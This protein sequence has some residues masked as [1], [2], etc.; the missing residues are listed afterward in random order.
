[1]IAHVVSLFFVSLSLPA[2]ALVSP[3]AA[4]DHEVGGFKCHRNIAQTQS[5]RTLMGSVLCLCC[6]FP[7]AV[8][9]SVVGRVPNLQ[10]RL[11]SR[12]SQAQDD[13]RAR[14]R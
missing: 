10:T 4:S 8:H 13:R 14:T 7:E 1:M 5:G 12:D 11:R 3:S 9:L 2:S 6:R